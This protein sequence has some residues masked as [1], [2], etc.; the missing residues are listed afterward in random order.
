MIKKFSEYTNEKINENFND[1]IDPSEYFGKEINF[2][3]EDVTKKVSFNVKFFEIDFDKDAIANM[4]PF[5][6]E[7]AACIYVMPDDSVEIRSMEPGQV[8]HG[9][10]DGITGKDVRLKDLHRDR[11]HFHS[12]E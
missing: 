2:V 9:V 6:I 3:A 8:L 12:V 11:W 1:F 5:D 7:Y 4:P 10:I